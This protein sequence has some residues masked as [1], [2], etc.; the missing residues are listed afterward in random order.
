MHSIEGKTIGCLMPLVQAINWQ[1]VDRWPPPLFYSLQ[2]T[3]CLIGGSSC[4]Y[5]TCT[6]H[7]CMR[8][9]DMLFEHP[10][11]ATAQSTPPPTQ[12]APHKICWFRAYRC[13]SINVQ[14]GTASVERVV[15]FLSGGAGDGDDDQRD[16]RHGR[17]RAEARGDEVSDSDDALEE[18]RVKLRSA[19]ARGAAGH[20]SPRRLFEYLDSD[21]TGEVTFTCAVWC[22]KQAKSRFSSYS[23]L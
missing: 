20:M 6:Y 8:N 18:A 3:L 2:T 12:C 13:S 21:G 16:K 11:S 14:D 19:L 23:C 1:V 4:P 9:I 15:S 10:V 17:G 22:H 5:C 7:F